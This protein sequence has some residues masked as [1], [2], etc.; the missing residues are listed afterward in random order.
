MADAEFDQHAI[1]NTVLF[2]K[3]GTSMAVSPG[4]TIPSSTK[5][6]LL[7]GED[8]DGKAR[9]M[10]SSL[11]GAIT[12]ITTD[13]SGGAFGEV[14]AAMSESAANLVNKYGIDSKE[15]GQ[16]LTGGGTVVH[17]PAQSAIRLSVTSADGD[18][19]KIR[20]NAYYRYQPGKGMRII[21]SGYCGDSGQANQKRRWGFFDD[22]DGIFWELD[23]T[24]LCTVVRSSVSG[25]PVDTRIAQSSW[26]GDKLDG[27][28]VS[29][30]TLDVTKGNIYEIQFQWLG[31]GAIKFFIDGIL[32]NTVDNPNT[33][34]GPF[35]RTAVL[36]LSA[37]ILN[38][39]SS[40]AGAFTTICSTINIE[41][42]ADVPEYS[43]G[44]Y[45]PTDVSVT[46]TER[47]LL[48]IR[49]K[50]LFNSIENRMSIFP[51]LLGA[52]NEGGRSAV[53]L[54]LDGTLTGD[55]FVSAGD[56]SGVEY[57]LSATAI[58]GGSTLMRLFLPQSEDGFTVDISKF[59]ASLGRS[60]RRDA[61]GTGRRV[62]TI[63]GKYEKSSGSSA[64]RASLTWGEA[65]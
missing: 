10:R 53:R 28:G 2:D 14:R 34:S 3:E 38:Y 50:L 45:N 65:R 32:V 20:T 27:S 59:F 17:L 25:S 36:P 46:T 19:A 30:V 11:T 22:N 37:E 56:D 49:P 7:V 61:F 16:S 24:T 40:S 12:I 29:E 13:Y 6:V 60:L 55:S 64:M 58:S 42:S 39:G 18:I 57:D 33:L 26:T 15:W 43:F 8:E 9:V 48:S 35:M 4:V 54:V 41:G 51:I 21:Q 23:G 62:L 63:T 47:P 44:A 52:S 31:V 1:A 5:G